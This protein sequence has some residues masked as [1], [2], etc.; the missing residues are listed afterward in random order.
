MP[1]QLE[2]E[3]PHFVWVCGLKGLE[4]QKWETL[5]YGLGGW[6]KNSVRAAYPLTSGEAR[7][8]LDELA[9]IYP[10]PDNRTQ[11]AA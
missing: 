10:R 8:T 9:E 6:R 4:P 2:N 1:A 5:D 11:H 7:L 3:R